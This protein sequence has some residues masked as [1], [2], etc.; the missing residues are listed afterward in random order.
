M[1]YAA[2]NKTTQIL[3]ESGII[4][5]DFS[6]A[7]VS[8][9]FISAVATNHGTTPSDV[10]FYYLAESDASVTRIRT[11]DAW[12]LTWD[13]SAPSGEVNGIGFT[14]ED[15]KKWLQFSTDKTEIGSDGNDKVTISVTMLLANKSGTDTSFSG[16]LTVPISDPNGSGKI[17][18]V[19]SSGLASKSLKFSQPGT[20]SLGVSKMV[21]YRMDNSIHIDVT[22]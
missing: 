22:L 20:V 13:G 21:D 4:S 16:N 9:S 12:T 6:I 19:F 10:S 2:G 17:K 18:F 8:T 14:T 3:I 7:S 11:G 5:L 1:W 15:A